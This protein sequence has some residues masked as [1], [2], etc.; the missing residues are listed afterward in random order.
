M[1]RSVWCISL[2]IFLYLSPGCGSFSPESLT[3]GQ[4][5]LSALATQVGV[6]VQDLYHQDAET[7]RLA[8]EKSFGVHVE[9]IEAKID[10]VKVTLPAIAKEA[11]A[12]GGKSFLEKVAE[13]PTTSGIGAAAAGAIGGIFALW[14]R[15]AK[16]AREAYKNGRRE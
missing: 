5:Q 14:G 10:E 13:N 2:A 3:L 11:A 12:V 15:R 1:Q 6:Q 16:L 9:A 8:A 7:L 4:D